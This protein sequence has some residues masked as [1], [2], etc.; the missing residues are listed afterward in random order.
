MTPRCVCW[1]AIASVG[2]GCAASASA[3]STNAE[4]GLAR[5]FAPPDPATLRATPVIP[6]LLRPAWPGEPTGS[7]PLVFLPAPVPAATCFSHLTPPT[8]EE[9]AALESAMS[10]LMPRFQTT[11]RWSGGSINSPRTLTWSLVPDGINIPSSSGIGDVAGPS[12]LFA[13]MDAKFGG[14]RALWIAQ[15][16]AAF[17][18]WQQL[19]GVQFSRVTSFGETDDGSSFPTAAGSG[20]RGDIRISMRNVDG[21]NRVLAYAYFPETG[22]IVIDSSENWQS[23]GFTYAY[24]RSMLAHEIGHALGLLHVCPNNNTKLM[25]PLLVTAFDGPQHDD[26]RAVQT[27]YGDVREPNGN[28]ASATM[29]PGTIAGGSVSVGDIPAPAIAD[30]SILAISGTADVDFFLSSVT[31]PTLATITA[32]PVGRTYPDYSQDP[33]CNNSTAN[34]NSV[35]VANLTVDVFATNGVSAWRTSNVA[36]IGQPEVAAGV[37]LS[38]PGAYY[39]R[40]G[41]SANSSQAQQYTLS[42][43]N[44]Q[45]PTLGASTGTFADRV[46]LT[47]TAIPQVFQYSLFRGTTNVRAN[48]TL[49]AN[50]SIAATTFD[51]FTAVSGVTYFYW[52]ECQQGSGGS[53][54]V[55]GPSSGVRGGVVPSNNDCASAAVVSAGTTNGTTINA[56]NDGTAACGT[57]NS[58]PDVWYRFT[59]TCT[60]SVSFRVTGSGFLPVVS[61]HSV[62]GATSSSCAAAG[63]SVSDLTAQLTAGTEVRVRVSGA[64]GG[65]GPFTLLVTPNGP[66]NNACLN[67]ATIG[68][69]SRTFDTCSAL[70]TG[71]D[72]LLCG[73]AGAGQVN[74]DVWYRFTAPVAGRTV[75][76]T[77]GSSFDTRVALYGTACPGSAGLA[78]ACNDDSCGV[79][80]RLAFQALAGASYLIRVGG[81]G[82]ARGAGV[83]A[84]YCPGDFNQD[85]QNAP[86]DIFA[87][88]NSY[89]AGEPDADFDASGSRTPADIFAFLNAYFGG[90]G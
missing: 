76:S 66:P 78:L 17:D 70:T 61:V 11:S 16:Q 51:D 36:G 7:G 67:A 22:D 56:T 82:S 24:F 29:I 47:W 63:G 43:T 46:R 34:T 83:L 18:R 84:V 12:T 87:F 37:L 44:I 85:G 62:C 33:S 23:P 8:P 26:L 9:R 4:R 48:A 73:G 59:P 86:A 71:F 69:G 40:V 55:A 21:I 54:P 81:S 90:C 32:T 10:S 30:S 15:I 13:S 88:L 5:F 65:A 64:S 31:G 28:V 68:Y 14:D 1:L 57:S 35:S 39:I 3:R 6:E 53:R 27:L 52:L 20:T 72:E 74:A 60:G 79:Q 41:T 49:L 50:P 77:C 75:V 38:P 2:V 80:A 42:I 58:S 89:F 25:E 19:A 45:T